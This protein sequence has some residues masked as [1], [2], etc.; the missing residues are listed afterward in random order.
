LDPTVKWEKGK[1]RPWNAELK[2]LC[3][4]AGMSFM[5]FHNREDCYYGKLY[6]ER[7]EYETQRNEALGNKDVALASMD[8]VGKTTDAYKFYSEGK[9]P[10]AQIDARARRW[11]VKIFLSHLHAEMYRKHFGTE[12]PKPFAIAILGHAHMINPPT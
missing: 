4:K 6:K 11:V 3:W 7:K 9:L 1:K 5:K 8:R 12:P 10:P 2:V